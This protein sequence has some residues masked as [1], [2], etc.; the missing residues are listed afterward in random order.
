[1]YVKYKN[2]YINPPRKFD[3]DPWLRTTALND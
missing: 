2:I 1:M 3:E